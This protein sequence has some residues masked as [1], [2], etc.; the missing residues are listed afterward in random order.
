MMS[1][2]AFDSGTVL[3]A[4]C[5]SAFH[6]ADR[7]EPQRKMLPLRSLKGEI[8]LLPNSATYSTA[9]VYIN[10]GIVDWDVL[11]FCEFRPRIDNCLTLHHK[12]KIESTFWLIQTHKN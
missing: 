2:I 8:G 9:R 10:V 7:A 6:Q 12:N 4:T 1:K 3:M 5:L 11:I